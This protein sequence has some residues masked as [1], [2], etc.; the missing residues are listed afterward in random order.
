MGN[1]IRVY[2][3]YDLSGELTVDTGNHLVVA[4]VMEILAVSRQAAQK[5]SGERFNL[6]MLNKREV[7]K[8]YQTELT[9]KFA[10]LG[11]LK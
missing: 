9:N 1:G 11:N 7:R 8:Q 5:F 10:A 2:S 3:M 6:R 4:K